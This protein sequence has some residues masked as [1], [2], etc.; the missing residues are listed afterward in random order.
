MKQATLTFVPPLEKGIT[1]NILSKRLPIEGNLAWEYNPFRNYRL[2]E[3]KYYFRD[4]YF[5]PKELLEELDV[6]NKVYSSSNSNYINIDNHQFVIGNIECF[7]RRNVKHGGIVQD[8][9]LYIKNRLVRTVKIENSRFVIDS[10]SF[11]LLETVED[12]NN[13]NLKDWT[14][15]KQSETLPNGIRDNENDPE[16][17][18]AGQLVDF[19]TPELKFNVHNPVDLLP[20]YSYDGSVNLIVNDGLNQ[21]KLINSR[22]SPIGRNKYK[23][24]DRKGNNDTNIY[25][26]GSQFDIDTSLYKTYTTIPELEFINVYSNGNLPIGNY[27]FYFRYVDADENETDFVAESGLVSIFKGNTLKTIHSGFRDEDSQKSVKFVLDNVDSAYQYVNVYYTRSTADIYSNP[28]IKA[29]KIEQKFFVNNSLTCH[30]NIT[31]NEQVTEIPLT[32]L[33]PTFQLAENVQTQAS[34]QNMLFFGNIR[35]KTPNYREL[36]DLSLRFIPQYSTE[37]YSPVD[38]T[39]SQDIKDTY[40]DPRFIYNNTGYQNG[41]IYRF[42]V[43]YI[44]NDGSLSPVFNIRGLNCTSEAK[45]SSYEIKRKNAQGIETRNYIAYNEDTGI[46]YKDPIDL[47]EVSENLENIFGVTKI[48]I[49][50]FDEFR[51]IIGI[52]IIIDK[53]CKEDLFNYLRS[54]HVKGLFFVRQKRIPNRLC[55]ALV[56]GIDPE[57]NTPLLYITGPSLHHVSDIATEPQYITERF[58]NNNLELVQSF[59]ERLY[60]IS[61]D[62]VNRYGAFCPEYDVNSPYLNTLF[63]GDKY[64]VKQASIDKTLSTDAHYAR[65]FYYEPESTSNNIINTVRILGVE[66]NVKLVT[67][68]DQMFSA[69]AG[70][71]EEVRYFEYIDYKNKVSDA[72]NLLRG[73]YGPYL[74][75]DGYYTPGTIINIYHN[76]VVTELIEQFKKRYHDKSSFYAISNRMSLDAAE[77]YFNPSTISTFNDP[78]ILYRGDSYICT[79]THRVN[80]NFQDPS[81]P[82][83]SQIV[84]R[85]CWK[86][87]FEMENEA[88]KAENLDKI[89][90]GD[91]NAVPLGM[92]VTFTLVSSINLNIRAIDDSN[93]D[94]IALT[95]H[96][97]GFYPYNS[98]NVDGSFKTPE[99]LC[100]NKGFEKSLSERWNYEVPDVPFLKNEF[101]NRISYSDIAINDAFKN[102]FRTFQG[103]HYRDYPKTYGSITKLVELRGNLLCVFEHG[104]C[105]IPVNERAVAG[106]G[107]GGNIYINT[108]NVLPENPKII[109]DKFGSQWKESIIQTPKFIYGVD[110]VGKKIWRTNG[111]MFECISDF[112]IQEFLNNNIS[113][114]E[115]ELEP[116]IGVRNVKS[117]YNE[118][119]QDLMFTFYDNLYG[120]EEKVWNLCFNE[121]LNKWITFY[122]WVPSY[123]ENIYNQYFSFDRNTSKW[124]T[125]LGVSKANNNFSDGVVLSENVIPNDAKVGDIVGELSLANRNLPTGEGIKEVQITYSLEHDN[126]GNWKHFE[127]K[128]DTTQAKSYLCLKT[129]AI[130]LCSEFYVRGIKTKN[131]DEKKKYIEKI[132]DPKN[133][134]QEWIDN[135]VLSSNYVICK[136]DRG[137]RKNLDTEP[138]DL[139]VNPSQPVILL[140]I[141]ANI[142]VIS[143]DKIPT[144]F[145]EAAVNGFTNTSE[146]D[147]GYYQSVVAVI[148]K[149]NMQFLTTD[150][151]KHGQAGIIDIADK[152]APTYWYGK[153]HPFEFE[154]VVADNPQLHKIFDN[155]QIISNKAAPESFHYEIVG[156]CYDFA[157]D[158]KNMYIRQEA[159]KELY[160]FNGSDIVYNH[161]YKH[162]ISE[163]RQMEGLNTD[164]YEKSTIFPLYYSRQDT[165]NEIEDHYHLYAG[166][167]SAGQSLKNFSALSGAEIVRYPNLGEYRI[168]NHAKA[169]DIHDFK[170]GGRMRG[171]M[172]YKEDKWDIQI[173][174]INLVQRNETQSDWTN[175]F[176]R[177]GDEEKKMVPAECN[178]FAPPKE[179]YTEKEVQK[180]DGSIEIVKEINPIALPTDWERNIVSWGISDKLNK[181]VKLKDKFI[182]IRVRYSGKDLAIINALKTLYT[183]SYS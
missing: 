25:D 95:G 44:M 87:N 89:N 40:S 168:W 20:Q 69:R 120:F 88:I 180:P 53:N 174:P 162:L 17:Y 114:T 158:K 56:T 21:P 141:K 109:S 29:F 107:S 125:K 122:S 127:I 126:F 80:R 134:K 92:W 145:T 137:R 159:T 3:S 146:V 75:L 46:I 106:Q 150:F 78:L 121:K 172:Q 102:G 139:R 63:C 81:A 175:V 161:D 113:L 32:D 23:I 39:Y 49:S 160:Q 6:L 166:K 147:A 82:T 70:D 37:S 98:I 54:Y 179:L 71:A 31:G 22:F 108:S 66:D 30:I 152:I 91:V 57:S 76:E 170:K 90:L 35:N 65:H 73:S 64:I 86:D 118:F 115:R 96:P 165:I 42:G 135:C 176:R 111:D 129:D 5:S 130:N 101:S 142:K 60:A 119:K 169:V 41:E 47:E 104:V 4:K 100:Y 177:K 181:E 131:K 74:A 27:H 128:T 103:T 144:S 58:M 45:Y 62:K 148:P 15:F 38:H 55:Q 182:K 9:I 7:I 99:A 61:K 173:N 93:V 48:D 10:H 112:K 1:F 28:V 143:E 151:W 85:N 59:K 124:I 33:N 157:K 12:F 110:T 13:A 164:K 11:I 155:L 77:Q 153:Q 149:Y 34:C 123:S 83:N 79:F 18:E 154:F 72:S 94:E 84:N 43:V 178:L 136:D 8:E 51:N 163:P 2:S 97:R 50:N 116:V 26:Q 117:H 52:K 105:L 16:L 138:E 132:T 24:Q 167:D 133:Q 14:Y 156:E 19:D 140:N 67:I 183:I 36:A 171:N 68:D